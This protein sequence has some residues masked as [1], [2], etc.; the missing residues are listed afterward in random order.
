M[1]HLLPIQVSAVTLV[2]REYSG[3]A[4]RFKNIEVRAGLSSTLEKNPVVG[5]FIGP[6]V[7]MGGR[8]LISFPKLMTVEYLSIQRKEKG[9]LGLNGIIIEGKER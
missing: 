3:S 2:Q 5:K 8:N 4:K 9:I 7:I 6:S 1:I